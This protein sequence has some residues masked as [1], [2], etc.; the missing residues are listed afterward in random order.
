MQ[1]GGSSYVWRGY[2]YA[3]GSL[4]GELCKPA[5]E[6]GFNASRPATK[7]KAIELCLSF[8]EVEGTADT[9]IVRRL[10]T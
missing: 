1:R 7:V 5:I 2:A 8:V 10:W 3:F 4:S 6:K 9:V